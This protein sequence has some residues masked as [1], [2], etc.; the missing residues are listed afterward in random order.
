MAKSSSRAGLLGR[1]NECQ[2][3]DD[4]VAGARAGRS[5]ALVLRGEAG[6]GKTELLRYLLDRA[7][8]CHIVRVAGVQSEMELSYAGLHQLCA[9]LLTGLD[10]LPDPQRDAL[11]T[12]FGLRAGVAPDRFLVGL[13]TLSL[14]ADAGGNQPLVCLVDDAQWLDS[15]SALTLEFVA[16]RLLAESVALVFAV[17]EPSAGEAFGSL[18]E[19][20]VTG[21]T[22]RDSRT[23]LDSVVTGPLDQRVRDRIVA[24]TRGN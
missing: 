2:A 17:R 3:L 21:L 6:I 23:L 20:P 16:R 15:A 10:Q 19:L 22:E 18:P 5:A 14:V 4:L 8:G 13:A 11:S 1:Q 12:A 7:T 24:E 9:P